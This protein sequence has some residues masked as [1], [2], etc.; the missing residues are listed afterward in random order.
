MS[1]LSNSQS[2]V[3]RVIEHHPTKSARYGFVCTMSNQEIADQIGASR[4]YT[5]SLIRKLRHQH[6]IGTTGNTKNRIIYLASNSHR[7]SVLPRSQFRVFMAVAVRCDEAGI[8]R[9]SNRSLADHLGLRPA[10]VTEVLGELK[11]RHLLVI[12]GMGHNRNLRLTSRGRF[13]ARHPLMAQPAPPKKLRQSRPVQKHPSSSSS[14]SSVGDFRPLKVHS[15]IYPYEFIFKRVDFTDGVPRYAD[16]IILKGTNFYSYLNN[17]LALQFLTDR[18]HSLAVRP[19][20]S[21]H[22]GPSVVNLIK[23]DHQVKIWNSYLVKLFNRYYHSE[24]HPTYLY[25]MGHSIDNWVVFDLNHVQPY[26]K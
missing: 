8:A 5:A 24:Q 15:P 14:R 23:R 3:F 1:Q 16:Q 6:L 9:V 2:K 20:P 19:C 4:S 13:L 12:N 18:H 25:A 26:Y 10:N 7:T 22:Q 11:R 21:G 17:C